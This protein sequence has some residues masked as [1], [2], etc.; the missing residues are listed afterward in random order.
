MYAI[1]HRKA[2]KNAW[3]WIVQFRRCGHEHR[4]HFSDLKHGGSEPAR[5]AAIAWRDEQL[6]KVQVLSMVEFCQLQRSNNTS[7]VV[8]VHYLTTPSQ[9][10]GIWQ[11]KVKINGKARHKSFSV[12]L[13]GWQSA[14]DQAV[15]AREQLLSE[16]NDKPYLY[17]KLAKKLA[18]KASV[19][20]SEGVMAREYAISRLPR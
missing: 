8:G 20:T 14:Y 7:G 19:N 12:L 6:A 3:S 9:P 4:K 11:A 1:S 18:A 2:A 13:H 16:A 10:H 5:K 15:A 17:D